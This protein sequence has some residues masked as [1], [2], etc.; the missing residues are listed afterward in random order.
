MR[1]L[2]C[3]ALW[4][5]G[6]LGAPLAQASEASDRELEAKLL[7]GSLSLRGVMSYS[8]KLHTWQ[9]LQESGAPVRLI[10]LWSKTCAPCLAELPELKA[11][12][13]QWQRT[14]RQGVQFLFIADPPDQTSRQDVEAFWTSP[15]AD[16]LAK[17]C[18][19]GDGV[20]LGTNPA[21]RQ[22]SC[23]LTVPEQDP[24]RSETEE[25]ARSLG[26][27]A[28]RPLTL[29]VDQRGTIRQVFVGSL[30]GKRV[31]VSDAIN[32]LR[33]AVGKPPGGSRLRPAPR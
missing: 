10:N 27:A 20:V 21:T 30:R 2:I 14:D 5:V 6:M 25:L 26:E 15:Y 18:P 17:G 31:L 22:P 23:L 8:R 4:G 33:Q 28:T 24:A 12:A 19:T 3:A 7:S 1:S 16:A 11:L 32:R 29:L 9:P 13:A